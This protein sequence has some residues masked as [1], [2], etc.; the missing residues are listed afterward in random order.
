VRGI[1][2]YHEKEWI[3]GLTLADELDGFVPYQVRCVSFVIIGLVVF[4]PL[5]LGKFFNPFL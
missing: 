2:G 4:M 5:Q 1:E 3:A